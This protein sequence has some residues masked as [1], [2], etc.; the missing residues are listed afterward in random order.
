MVDTCAVVFKA[1]RKNDKFLSFHFFLDFFVILRAFVVKKTH[2]QLKKL[3][4]HEQLYMT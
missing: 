4:M 2:E 1:R 3:V